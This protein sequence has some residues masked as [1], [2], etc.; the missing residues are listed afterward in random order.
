V[1]RTAKVESGLFTIAEAFG[2]PSASGVWLFFSDG[3][4]DRD[5]AAPLLP[6]WRISAIGPDQPDED[7]DERNKG[8][9][10]AA[11]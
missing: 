6:R 4:P 11:T 8:D 7:G 3:T 9:E 1:I 5:E 2:P 10:D